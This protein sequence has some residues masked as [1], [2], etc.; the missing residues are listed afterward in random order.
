MTPRLTAFAGLAAVLT[1]AACGQEAG[2]SADAQANGVVNVYSARHYD[3][4]Q[5]LY[6]MFTEATGISVNRIE[7]SAPQLI[8]RMQ[9][10]GAASPADVFVA[11][12]AGALWRAQEAGLLSPVASDALNA[13]VPENLRDPEGRWYGFQRRA[14]VV[15]YD[16]ARVQ[17]N[18]IATYEDI[19]SPRF[20][21]QL[22]VRS[23]DNVYNLSL[24]GALIEAWGPEKTAEWARG[25][26]AN[27]A[28]QPE[29]GDR[30]QIRAVGAGVC[31]IALTNSYYY[32]R[33]AAGDDAGDRA[34]T[35]TVKLG[36]P[37][38]DGQGA[39][40]NISGGGVAANAPNR[41]AAIRFL[42]FLASPEA[43]TLVSQENGEYPAS[44]GV[45]VP[46]PTA[47]YA[48]FTAHP[49]PVAAYGPRQAEAQAL[50]TAA[51]WR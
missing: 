9:S 14:R 41:E 46:A 51:G 8:A 32:V 12:D 5:K 1:L 38:L 22:C 18:E 45:A 10:E 19:A 7:G 40:V 28:R 47:T 31:Q 39:H 30:D 20:R 35:Q 37:S 21:G 17:P 33:M 24:V 11:A 36:F 34:V 4:D 13:A 16:Q 23:S 43:Q 49:M 3:V 27:L 25:V 42:E 44:P 26:V 50:M 48:E 15:A 6:T 2:S 29:G